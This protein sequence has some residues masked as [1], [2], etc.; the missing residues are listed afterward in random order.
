[1]KTM[2]RILAGLLLL[3]GVVPAL[4]ENK[5][6][7]PFPLLHETREIW[8][9]AYN[10]D[11]KKQV[12]DYLFDTAEQF[13]VGTGLALVSIDGHYGAINVDGKFIIEPVYDNI[14]Y[15]LENNT[16]IVL[17]GDKYGEINKDGDLIKP[18]KYESLTPQNKKGWYEFTVNGEYFYLAPNG[19]V[20]SDWNEYL[21]APYE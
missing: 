10:Y 14:R 21:N 13:E 2:Y 9:Y 16:Y 8:G 17:K 7:Y 15:N 3:T 6:I 5:V 19:H 11:R 1:M 4:G 18:I 12:I 20:T